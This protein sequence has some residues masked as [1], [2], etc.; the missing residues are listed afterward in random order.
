L[1]AGPTATERRRG[2]GGWFSGRTS[3]FLRSVTLT[4]GTA[5]VDF[6]DL[7]RVIPNASSSCGSALLLAQLDRTATQFP[8]VRRAVYSLAGS[9]TAFYEWL[10]L[11]EPRVPAARP[12]VTPLGW[13]ERS[14]TYGRHLV[15]SFGVR[16]LRMAT[17]RWAAVV[18]VRNASN[19]RIA[20]E[21][22][23]ALLA[24]PAT[25]APVVLPAGRFAPR[26]PRVLPI[27]GTW[28]GVVSGRGAPPPGSRVRLRLGRFSVVIAPSMR[29]THVTRHV[30]VLPGA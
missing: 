27:L 7:R 29:F 16:E 13:Q 22:R 11:A 28:T 23:F 3:G 8:S 1:L 15:M 6:R 12:A 24:A 2:Y 19:L 30:L 14:I 20:I 5:Y 18:S 21:N 26:L 25:G 9:R 17:D 4:G 10:Q